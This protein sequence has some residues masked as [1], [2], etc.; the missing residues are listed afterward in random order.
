MTVNE[1]IKTFEN[2]LRKLSSKQCLEI[3]VNMSF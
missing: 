1:K 3:L 2:K